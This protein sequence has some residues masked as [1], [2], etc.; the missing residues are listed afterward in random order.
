M[1]YLI[2]LNKNGASGEYIDWNSSDLK[3]VWWIKYRAL[4]LNLGHI[5]KTSFP[6][7]P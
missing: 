3:W 1:K 2:P 6:R 7:I 5:K 4:F